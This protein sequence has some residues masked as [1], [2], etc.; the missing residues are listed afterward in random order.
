MR[1]VQ[2]LLQS[3][4]LAGLTMPAA[5]A[6]GQPDPTGVSRLLSLDVTVLDSTGHPVV[7]GLG[8]AD[9]TVTEDQQ[10]QRILSFDPPETPWKM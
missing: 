10:Q 9:F 7:K 2:A 5:M 3:V 1:P 6:P 4:L 8:K